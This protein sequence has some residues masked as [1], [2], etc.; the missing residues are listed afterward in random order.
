MVFSLSNW[1]P[2]LRNYIPS[3]TTTSRNLTGTD[4]KEERKDLDGILS[5]IKACDGK[6]TEGLRNFLKKH[7]LDAYVLVP[8]LSVTP[9]KGTLDRLRE[10]SHIMRPL[11]Y[12]SLIAISVVQD[13]RAKNIR[14]AAWILSLSMDVFAEWPRLKTLVAGSSDSKEKPS[15]IEEEEHHVRLLKF[16]LYLLREP[17]MSLASHDYIESVLD[18]LSTWRLLKPFV[19]KSYFLF[20]YSYYNCL[21]TAKSYEKLCE[22]VVYYTLGS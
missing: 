19:S 1:R 11:V 9:C 4:G 20:S 22:K 15:H 16:F 7:R 10:V 2:T 17:V 3:F 12:A 8:E 5:E 21:E 18:T 14:W 13:K 6:E